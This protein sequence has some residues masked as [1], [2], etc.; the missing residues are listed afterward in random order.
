VVATTFYI[1]LEG[2]TGVQMEPII[3]SRITY[4]PKL[5]S[6][7]INPR[8]ISISS[9]L[10]IRLCVTMTILLELLLLLIVL[11]LLHSIPRWIIGF[12]GL[13]LPAWRLLLLHHPQLLLLRQRLQH[14]LNNPVLLHQFIRFRRQ[15]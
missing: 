10:I 15:L 7:N 13:I 8:R 14:S 3:S 12:R 2:Q 5:H 1:R 11:L 9:P 4:E 6:I